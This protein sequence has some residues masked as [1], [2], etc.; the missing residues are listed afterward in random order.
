[1]RLGITGHRGL[2]AEV[3]RL[4]RRALRDEVARRGPDLVGVSCIADGPDAWFAELVL[5]AG[6]RLEV[7]VPA[8]QYREGL[9]EEHHQT[10]DRLIEQ[11]ADIH[12]TGMVESDSQAH[13]AGS[14]ILVGLVDELVAVWDGQP[15]R[16]Y[17]GTADVVAYAERTGVRSRVIWPEGATRD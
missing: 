13:M 8:E 6:G 12:R 4:V 17:G 9:P 11:A 14:E 2:S 3:E 10:Y 1:M 5:E 16:G 15:A 7:V